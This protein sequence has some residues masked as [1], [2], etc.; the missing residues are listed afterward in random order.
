M[1][2]KGSLTYE[3]YKKLF[4]SK[5][6][7]S[8]H[9]N[10][11]QLQPSS[12]DLTLSDECYEIKSSF[13]SPND[14]I[15]NKLNSF[16]K[17]KINLKHGYTLKKNITYL[18]NLNEKLKLPKKIF[19]KCNPK[20]STG[21]LDIFCRTI[22]DY[23][24]EYEKI[25][26]EYSGEIFLEVTS[27]AFN[28]K[29]KQG[30][31]LNQMRL[32]K[33]KNI[34]LDDNQ[35]HNYHIK[36]PII[37]NSSNK[38]IVPKVSNG[39]KISVDLKSNNSIV[40]YKAKEKAPVLIFN[41][42][43]AHR[44]NDFWEPLINKN[45][46]LMI[47]PGKFYILKSKEKIK[48]PKTMAGEMIP[49]DTA[50]GDFRAHYAGFFDPGFGENNGSHAVL[51]VRTNEVSF[52]LEDGQIIATLLYENL[53]KIPEVTYGSKINSNYQNQDLALSKHFNVLD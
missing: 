27:R 12:I 39:L 51:E 8:N 37:F 34:I 26:F 5:I 1:L 33:G 9:F 46:S 49:Y 4:D 32:V 17:K 23:C 16:I 30:D 25:P 15:R 44:I 45:N 31:S 38:P 14:N 6:I 52:T 3:D 48:I 53:N 47:D 7:L 21:R 2:L 11:N 20:S 18:I 13:L 40:A 35:L 19:G 22:F 50:I 43:K 41:K 42:T 10:L 36:H 28:I 29:L 24:N